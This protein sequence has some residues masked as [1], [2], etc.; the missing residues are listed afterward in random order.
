MPV[1][2]Y[3]DVA[4]VPPAIIGAD[5]MTPTEGLRLACQLSVTALRLAGH[6]A[7]GSGVQRSSSV[8]AAER[9]DASGSPCDRS[10][11]G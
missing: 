4:D 5:D 10:T 8:A 9:S 11:R 3:R 1:K 6:T 2:R 7:G